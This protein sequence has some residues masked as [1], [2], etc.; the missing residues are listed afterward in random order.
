MNGAVRR[1]AAASGGTTHIR[2]WV[3]FGPSTKSAIIWLI[4]VNV[5]VRG[6]WLLWMHPPQLYDFAW[7]FHHSVWMAQGKGYIWNG[8]Y[9]AYW[10]IGYPFFLSLLWRLTGPH[11]LIGL[12][13]NAALSLCIVLLVYGLTRSVL[14]QSR[15]PARAVAFAAALRYTLL[16]SHVEWNAVL[17]SEELATFL[18][19]LAF[20]VYLAWTGGSATQFSR[21][22]WPTVVAG[23]LLGLSCDV[24]PIPLLFPVCIVFYERWSMHRSWRQAL[25]RAGVFAAAMLAAVA[26]VTLRNF[27]TMHHFILISTN[28]GVNLWQ[29]TH[30]NGAY[31]WSWNPKVNPLLAAHGNEIL[32]NQI[33]MHVAIQYI[34]GHPLLT[35]VNGVKKIFYLYWVDW[36]VIGVTFG[37]FVPKLPV[38]IQHIAAW[39]NTVVYWCWMVIALTGLTVSVRSRGR[40]SGVAW[41]PLW[42]IGYNTAVFLF[43]PAW[44]RFR[45][46]LMPLFAVYFGMG[47]IWLLYRRHS[48]APSARPSDPS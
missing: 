19:M 39:F 31:F 27:L 26:P 36:N 24:R 42:Y 28:G 1:D 41:F 18:L 46:P 22:G 20:L 6:G 7:Y 33:G 9:T 14:A 37:N 32:K 13:A 12:V 15:W 29:G 2:N 30:S 40:I 44:D 17:G 21:W 8:H 5:I 25:L 48:I 35:L 4:A 34:L 38:V 16:P 3:H 43:F 45:F 23:I 11:V 10:P 47:W